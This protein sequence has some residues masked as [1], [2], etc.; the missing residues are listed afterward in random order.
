MGMAAAVVGAGALGAVGTAVAASSAAGAQRD[1][2]A[3][4]SA[5]QSAMYNR[6]RND[7]MPYN[8]AGQAGMNMLMGR[9][10]EFTSPIKMDQ[11]TLE[12]TPGYQFNLSQGLKSVQNSAAARGL[13]VS[14]AAMKG[15]AG[16]ATGLADQTYQNQFN[17]AVTNQTNAYNRLMGVSTLG[18]SAAAQTGAMGTQTAANIGN[19]I[20]GAGNATAGSYMAMGNAFGG[21]ANSMG[22][23]Y[24]MNRMYG[25]A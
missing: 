4:A 8:Q 23:A 10:G 21:L 24:M 6:T 2:A 12:Q 16:Y 11:A 22:Q 25:G 15:A 9:M 5:T 19:N 7:L 18:Q 14:G 17:N 3:Q 20:I 13:G 1:A